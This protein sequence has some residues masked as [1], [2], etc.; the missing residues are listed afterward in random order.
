MLRK[1]I[2]FI[3]NYS[4]LLAALCFVGTTYQLGILPQ[5]YFVCLLLV[6]GTVCVLGFLSRKCAAAVEIVGSIISGLLAIAF[7]LGTMFVQQINYTLQEIISTE[8]AAVVEEI[9]PEPEIIEEEQEDNASLEKN[10]SEEQ[11]TFVLYLSGIDV[12]GDLKKVSRSDVNIMVVV[13]QTNRDI[14]LVSTPRDYYVVLPGI[15][16]DMKDKL[17]HAGIYGVDVSRKTLEAL[18]DVEID[19]YA[20]VNFS[21][22]IKIIDELGGLEVYCEQPFSFGNGKIMEPGIHHFNGKETLIFCRERYQFEDGDFQRGKNQEAVVAAIIQKLISPEILLGDHKVFDHIRE[23]LDMDVSREKLQELIGN[24]LVAKE[25]WNITSVAAE[26][27]IVRQ[28]CYSVKGTAL[29]VV[30][31]DMKSVEEI[32]IK[33]QET[34]EGTLQITE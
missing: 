20:R 31:P 9:I 19:Y 17:T 18:Y 27:E 7:L 10:A 16:G 29:S 4:M 28:E 11:K 15:S 14:L 6:L 34:L 1:R 13:N 23:N 21:S 5:N 32:K 25:G 24:E 8:E 22:L 33:I 12:Y 2:S 30:E 26:G 3:T